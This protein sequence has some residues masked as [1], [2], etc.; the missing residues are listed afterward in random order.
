MISSYP[1]QLRPLP[2]RPAVRGGWWLVIFSLLLPPSVLRPPYS[3]LGIISYRFRSSRSECSDTIYFYTF[4]AWQDTD[5][6]YRS[7]PLP[8]MLQVLSF[9]FLP[10]TIK[11]GCFVCCSYKM[12]CVVVVGDAEC[13]GAISS[14]IF[15]YS[16][17]LV[18]I[19]YTSCNVP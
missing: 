17:V 9:S 4:S 19:V 7:H 1:Q 13:I 15:P 2:S 5:R 10:I 11:F 16:F 3:L 6:A 14:Y 12:L 8:P 18:C